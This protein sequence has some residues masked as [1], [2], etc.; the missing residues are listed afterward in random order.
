MSASAAK[1]ALHIGL[2]P[3]DERPVNTRYPAM[4]AAVGGA[5][6][7]VPPPESLSHYRQAAPA[8]ALLGWLRETA[9]RLDALIVSVEMLGFGGLIPS[10]VGHE[11]LAT[12]L[13]R[14][15]VLW[16]LKHDFPALALYGFNVITR[17]PAYNSAFEEPEYWGTH[18][19]ALWEASAVIDQHRQQM[20]EGGLVEQAAAA[21]PPDVYADFTRR[22]LR[23]HLVNLA[24]IELWASGVFDLLVL[25]SDDTS[26]YGFSTRE[27]AWLRYWAEVLPLAD[28]AAMHRRPLLMYPGA[29]EVGSALVARLMNAH[30]ALSPR[31]EVVY[32]LPGEAHNTA[33]YEDG[34]VAVT[35]ERQIAAVGGSM[36]ET[37]AGG[38]AGADA[39]LMINPPVTGAF[40]FE[41]DFYESVREGRRPAL[42]AFAQA[43]KARLAAGE[44]VIVA[45]VAYPNGADPL[46]MGCLLAEGVPLDQ[47]AAYAGWNTAGNTL[48]TA[49]AQGCA[50]LAA[51]DPTAQE[52]LLCHRLVED[53]GY[54][55][56]VRADMR[57]ALQAETG[58]SEVLPAHLAAV[59]ARIETA[60]QTW[61][62]ALPGLGGRW[63]ITP[64]SVRLPWKRLFEV[65]FDL[66]PVEA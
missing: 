33:P 15:D 37:G 58:S 1:P 30:Q 22:R 63:R 53:W 11:T 25:S 18:G 66:E 47:L 38:A 52:R 9:P 35:V 12:V 49:L 4:T 7:H 19:R 34:P 40:E 31:F 17:I 65:D 26:A 51:A 59:A 3:L 28:R 46:L 41:P 55:R 24:G 13:Q 21:I 54:Q 8:E 56:V 16:K 61:L 44:R 36:A 5:L 32:A 60:L 42:T 2:I 43:I 57:A 27:K 64:G 6:V 48:G 10:R 14:L 39:V 62:A 50:A 29:D 23:N 20:A 45:D